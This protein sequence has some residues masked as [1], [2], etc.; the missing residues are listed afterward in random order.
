MSSI[1]NNKSVMPL[2][3]KIGWAMII[4]IPAIIWC[5]PNTEIFT[6]QLQNFFAITACAILMLGFEVVP[7]FIPSIL[8][9]VMY[10]I[11]KVASAEIAFSSWTN[12]LPWMLL[13]ALLMINT[14]ERI[15]L[16]DRVAYYI[17]I[18]TGG[19]YKGLL[20]GMVAI[21]IIFNFF[22]TGA[23]HITLMPIAYGVCR[24]LKLEGTDAAAGI[25]FA[26][27]LGANLPALIFYNPGYLGLAMG[28][29]GPAFGVTV[30]WLEA[31]YHNLIFF[32]MIFVMLFFVGKMFKPK[33]PMQ[34]IG[35]F[36]EKYESLGKTTLEE[37]KA[38]V[39]LC[40][41]VILLITN[42]YHKIGLGWCFILVASAFFM[43]GI[44]IGTTGDLAKANLPLVL[45]VAA[46]MGIGNV[47][48]ALN[49]GQ[50]IANLVIPLLQNMGVLGIMCVV[51]CLSVLVNFLMTP[52]AA[53]AAF[54]VPMVQI[55]MDL[56][57][58]P[59]PIIYVMN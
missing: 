56:N 29:T 50:I 34:D 27:M 41:L 11:F 4:L 54:T 17:I 14:L 33:T 2:K 51:W 16:L 38:A 31:L 23:N 42:S 35:Y 43:P 39:L 55:A 1:I 49:V 6:G 53:I 48:T 22:L 46:C 37:K 7:Y 9:P 36:K 12:F 5:I 8:L 15:G 52:L 47:S 44:N 57:V 18:K 24:S 28:I 20:I 45:F 21:G 58:N 25:M 19:T 26:A 40:I 13:M 30:G 10:I 32:P 59:L 3:H